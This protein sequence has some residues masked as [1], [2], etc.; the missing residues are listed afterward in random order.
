MYLPFCQAPI[1]S[2]S[3]QSYG[4]TSSSCHVICSGPLF[5]VLFSASPDGK[6]SLA[7]VP[8]HMHCLLKV[9]LIFVGFFLN[10]KCC[11]LWSVTSNTSLYPLLPFH[12]FESLFLLEQQFFN[13]F[14]SK[15]YWIHRI[16]QLLA[17][18]HVT[19]T[20]FL[21][22][23]FL[24]DDFCSIA[25]LFKARMKDEHCTKFQQIAFLE[26]PKF[27]HFIKHSF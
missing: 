26:H 16:F 24:L 19:L 7:D 27:R 1:F 14:A 15:K 3:I 5:C 18:F 20:Y 23:L 6:W 25:C 11:P 2:P 10:L 21:K 13:G 17:F 8:V 22:P 12:W 9:Q 4:L